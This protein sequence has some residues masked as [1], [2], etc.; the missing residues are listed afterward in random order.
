MLNDFL[1][2]SEEYLNDDRIVLSNHVL[3]KG[4]YIKINKNGSEE[5]HLIDDSDDIIQD[6]SIDWLR[7]VDYYSS[8]V[9]MDK[10]VDPKKKIHSNNYYS[11][12]IKIDILPFVG[13]S[14]KK[15]SEEEYIDSI[16]RYFNVFLKESKERYDSKTVK[17]IELEGLAEIDSEEVNKNKRILIGK[18]K[19]IIECIQKEKLPKNSYLKIFFETDISNY[20]REYERYLIP[21]IFNKND[22]NIEDNG[23]I[24]GL[25]D[26]NMGMNSKKPFLEHMTSHYKVPFRVSVSQAIRLKRFIEWLNQQKE[27]NG[28]GYIPVNFDFKTPIDVR[29]IAKWKSFAFIKFSKGTGI[30]LE[31]HDYFPI[32][33]DDLKVDKIQIIDH[34]RLS[35]TD[36]L[37][38]IKDISSFEQEV[39]KRLYNGKLIYNYYTEP[40]IKTGSFTKEQHNLL[41][42]SRKAMHDFFKKGDERS[43]R[44][45]VD[46]ITMKLIMEQIRQQTQPFDKVASAYNLR[47]AMLKY[48]NIRGKEDMGDRI[49]KLYSDISIKMGSSEIVTCSSDE[50]FYFVMGQ[51]IRYLLNQ[52]EAKFKKHDMVEPY[53]RTNKW[54]RLKEHYIALY[55]RYSHGVEL[56]ATRFNNLSSMIMGYIPTSEPKPNRDLI[57]AGL[58]AKNVIYIKKED[59]K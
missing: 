56:N 13:T 17:L 53:I 51:L 22:Y 25:S 47:L 34:M 30:T 37:E 10:P 45:I 1:K 41:I 3:S 12:F 28:E 31:D 50:E 5:I 7:Q 33:S 57:L 43:I 26:T 49:E 4:L 16:E 54:E 46:Q 6:D 35:K 14:E 48:F 42:I 55:E 38:E 8:L 18:T 27:I 40:K 2:M 36:D 11:F 23:I 15:L 39:N 58:M 19:H 21:K 9:S 32:Y 44:G 59:I 20:A 52:S 29:H 24:L